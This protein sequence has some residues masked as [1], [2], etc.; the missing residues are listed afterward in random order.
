[1]RQTMPPPLSLLVLPTAGFETTKG[2]EAKNE[3]VL[4]RLRAGWNVLLVFMQI[5][6]SV[7]N[8]KTGDK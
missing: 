4:Q 6:Y 7:L 1:M 2:K 3:R 8:K 5:V